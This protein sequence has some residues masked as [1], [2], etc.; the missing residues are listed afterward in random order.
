MDEGWAVRARVRTGVRQGVLLVVVLTMLGHA[1]PAAA[2]PVG[3]NEGMLAFNRWTLRYVFR[4]IARGYNFVMPKWG[5]RRVTAFFANLDGPRDTVNSLL[6]AKF[7]R[8]ATHGGRLV[9]N[10]TIGIAGFFDVGRDWFGWEAAPETFDETLGVW[11]IPL[12]PYLILP[13]IG[14]SSPRAFVGTVADGFLNPVVVI[15]PMF[16]SIGPAGTNV[17]WGSSQFVLRGVNLLAVEM[18][19]PR[20]PEARWESYERSKFDY[21]DYEI[22]RETFMQDEADRIAE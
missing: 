19:S 8:A 22:G 4:P 7:R 21:P 6:Q 2:E 5:Q 13:F 11:G 10:T 17:I 16:V 14:D 18:P 15:V 20:D 3:F 9:V 1:P 12:G